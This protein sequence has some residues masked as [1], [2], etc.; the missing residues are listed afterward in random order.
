MLKTISPVHTTH[1]PHERAPAH[2]KI[3]NKGDTANNFWLAKLNYWVQLPSTIT[4][5]DTACALYM[6]IIILSSTLCTES[7]L[8]SPPKWVLR[9]HRTLL[10]LVQII[11]FTQCHPHM[12]HTFGL[13]FNIINI[14]WYARTN[15][16]NTQWLWMENNFCLWFFLLSR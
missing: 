12:K 10:S 1:T 4:N 14:L 5:L 3:E 13:A 9:F 8:F 6:T 11:D 7:S 15:K 2:I 16:I